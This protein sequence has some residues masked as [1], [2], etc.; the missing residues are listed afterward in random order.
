MPRLVSRQD[1]C[2]VFYQDGCGIHPARPDV[3]RA[4]PFFRANL[5]DA[6]SFAMAREDCPG[7][8]PEASH[9]TFA[10][11]GEAFLQ[12]QG[13]VRAGD[14]D[15]PRAI[16]GIAKEVVREKDHERPDLDAA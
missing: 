5:I 14:E 12:S 9:E 15:V 7:I 6:A 4:W 11:Q 3:C 1:G 16:T 8:D 10:R 13:L 2:C